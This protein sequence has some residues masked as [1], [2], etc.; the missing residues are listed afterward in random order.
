MSDFLPGDLAYF[1]SYFC[2]DLHTC[3]GTDQVFIGTNLGSE[4]VLVTGKQYG[5]EGEGDYL[6]NC[7][8]ST[9][10]EGRPFNLFS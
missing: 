7:W 4:R 5:V 1:F 9:L 3:V 2:A 6:L 8:M 10:Y